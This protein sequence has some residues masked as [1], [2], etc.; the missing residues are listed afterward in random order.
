MGPSKVPSDDEVCSA[1]LVFCVGTRD[2]PL[3][4]Q[5]VTHV[6]EHVVMSL[7]RLTPLGVNDH[8]DQSHTEFTVAGDPAMVGDYLTRLCRH[9]SSAPTA[10]QLLK[11]R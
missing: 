3:H 1:R 4:E 6:V 5:G 8:V 2:R 7:L 9:L 10:D 11:C